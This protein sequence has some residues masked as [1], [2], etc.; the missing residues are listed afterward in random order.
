MATEKDRL[1]LQFKINVLP[2]KDSYLN[3]SSSP[4]CHMLQFCLLCRV[5]Q[6]NMGVSRKAHLQTTLEYYEARL[7][8][9][10][11][12]ETETYYALESVEFLLN[13]PVSDYV[14]KASYS[15]H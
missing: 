9:P 13:N 6:V 15:I 12:G 7:E 8:A 5:F 10:L 4:S 1:L 2:I 11:L 3:A 14:K